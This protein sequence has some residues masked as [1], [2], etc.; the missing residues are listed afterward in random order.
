MG[1]YLS[2]RG[3]RAGRTKAAKQ[4][5]PGCAGAENSGEQWG[6]MLA[7]SPLPPNGSSLARACRPGRPQ[8]GLVIH[9]TWVLETEELA[10]LSHPLLTL[11]SPRFLEDAAGTYDALQQ[12]G[13]LK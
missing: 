3:R 9:P 5:A 1:S 2:R 11:F 7:P 8:G 4:K 10:G 13:Y 6:F 12:G